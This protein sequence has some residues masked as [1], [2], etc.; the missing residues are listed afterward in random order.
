MLIWIS[1]LGMRMGGMDGRGRGM[2]ISFLGTAG[3]IGI[4]IGKGIGISFLG[5]NCGGIWGGICGVI[6]CIGCIGI[7][8]GIRGTAGGLIGIRSG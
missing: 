4:G 3:G 2:G 8:F 7:S 1:T 5:C 6:G